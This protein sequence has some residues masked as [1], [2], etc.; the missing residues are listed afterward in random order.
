M[1]ERPVFGVLPDKEYKRRKAARKIAPEERHQKQIGKMHHI[2][3]VT[4]GRR[5]KECVHFYYVRPG[6]NTYR[7]CRKFGISGG[8]ATDWRSNYPACGIF[9]QQE[10]SHV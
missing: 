9:Q 7:K 4:E 8:P 1:G 3:G 6:Q 5:C 10:E 2:Y